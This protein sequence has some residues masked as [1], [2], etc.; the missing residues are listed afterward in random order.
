[1]IGM[2]AEKDGFHQEAVSDCQKPLWEVSEGP[3]AL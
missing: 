3:Q 1:M 2:C